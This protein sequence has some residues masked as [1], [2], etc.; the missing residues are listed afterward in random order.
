MRSKTKLV[1]GMHRICVA[2]LLVFTLDCGGRASDSYAGTAGTSL[3]G[4][5]ATGIGGATTSDAGGAVATGGS[6]VV[7][8]RAGGNATA[9]SGGGMSSTTGG[10]SAVAGGASGGLGGT[11]GWSTDGGGTTSA[12][13]GGIAGFAC[14]ELVHSARQAVSV[15]WLDN[16]TCTVDEDCTFAWPGQFNC[17]QSCGYVLNV[18]RVNA[19]RQAVQEQ[20]QT[21]WY[22]GCVDA[23]FGSYPCPP[24]PNIVG[25]TNGR[26]D[27]RLPEI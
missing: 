9:A 5:N 24:P 15:I 10:N 19:M 17:V 25:C 26:C 13:F 1:K 27:G 22:G 2:P 20:C 21:F 18:T 23:N 7:G 6:S 12:G 11:T 3:T 14:N 8:G 16:S 4:G